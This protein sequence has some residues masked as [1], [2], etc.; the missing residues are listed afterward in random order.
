[1]PVDDAVLETE[2]ARAQ[3]EYQTVSDKEHKLRNILRNFESIKKITQKI[4][5]TSGGFDVVEK[6]PLDKGTGKELTVARRDNIFNEN[7]TLLDAVLA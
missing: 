6:I 4:P 3:V 1:M 7:K 2:I 5:N